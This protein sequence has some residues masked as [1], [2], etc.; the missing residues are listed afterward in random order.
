MRVRVLKV[1]LA[2]TSVVILGGCAQMESGEMEA[3]AIGE[4]RQDIETGCVWLVP[5]EGVGA[6]IKWPD[7]VHPRTDPARL[8][9]E[10][11]TVLANEG[12]TVKLI[13]GAGA[14]DEERGVGCPDGPIFIAH[15]ILSVTGPEETTADHTQ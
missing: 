14:G 1:S 8:E 11:G 9:D 10:D 3:L 4:L 2:L 12:D 13:G 5:S 7:G 15:R 6:V